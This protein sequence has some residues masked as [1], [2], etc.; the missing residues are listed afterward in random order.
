MAAELHPVEKVTTRCSAATRPFVLSPMRELPFGLA[1][2]CRGAP[3]GS[4]KH[5][6]VNPPTRSMRIIAACPAADAVAALRGRTPGQARG[7]LPSRRTPRICR[8]VRL[9]L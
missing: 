7:D 8:S 1:S 6:S 2:H 9:R 3:S 5:A 4:R